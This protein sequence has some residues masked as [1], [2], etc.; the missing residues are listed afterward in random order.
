MVNPATA[1]NLIG[2]LARPLAKP[3]GIALGGAGLVGA[4]GLGT[5]LIRTI[6]PL[7]P[8]ERERDLLA[9]AAEKAENEKLEGIERER[10][11]RDREFDQVQRSDRFLQEALEG[12]LGSQASQLEVQNKLAE[13]AINPELLKEI[14]DIRTENKLTQIAAYQQGAMNQTRE[15]TRR[16]I[17]SDTIKA[18]QGITQAEINRDTAI[19]LGMMQIA[20]QSGMPNPN[21][22]TAAANFVAQGRGAFTAPKSP[23]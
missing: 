2:R 11:Y 14:D 21:Q 16:Q 5:K 10:R 4:L 17:E 12:L 3:A 20:Y 13:A 7:G 23:I 6:D 8:T 1:V 18:W 22:L 19:G 9:K 15:L